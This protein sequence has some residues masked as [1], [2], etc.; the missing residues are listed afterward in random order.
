[1]ARTAL[2]FLSDDA[3]IWIFGASRRLDDAE[4]QHTLR[5]VDRFLA[6]WSAHGA[7]VTGAREFRDGQFLIIG[8]EK[9]VEMGGCSIDRLY[10]VMDAIGREYKLTFIN[11]DLVFFRNGDGDIH[12][13]P[14]AEF[15]SMVSRG[16]A[17]GDTVVFDPTLT[18]VID[19]RHGRFELP[20]AESW[21]ARAFGLATVEGAR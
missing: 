12:A 3:A 21:H 10:G 11:S 19:L 7:P 8:S 20:A 6:G 1:M 14:R 13:V 18:Q 15:R 2:S 9:D 16:Q 5:I 17:T 4:Q